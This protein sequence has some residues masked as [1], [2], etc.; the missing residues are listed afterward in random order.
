MAVGLLRGFRGLDYSAL[1][2]AGSELD[3]GSVVTAGAFDGLHRG[4]QH[5]LAKVVD[6]AKS[7]GLP[8]VAITFEPLPREFFAGS[9]RLPRLMSFREKYD[10]L[11]ELGI[12]YVL[13]VRFDD[14]IRTMSAEAF[15]KQLFVQELNAKH[16]II[17]D[18]FRF[19]ANAS[20]NFALLQSI[21]EKVGASVAAIDSQVVADERVS[22]SLIRQSLEQGN[23]E[24]AKAYLG[25]A[26]AI[27]GRVFPGQKLGRELGF[28]TANIQLRR[29]S[30]AMAGVYVVEVAIESG[31]LVDK[32]ATWLPAVANVGTK[33]TVT[34]SKTA[35]LEVHL[36]D[37][38]GD[39][40]GK[41]LTVR[42]LKKL[43]DE[44]KF[45]GLDALK[46]QIAIDTQAARD[47]FS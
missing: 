28:P 9:Q 29:R 22:S 3:A 45:S 14:T 30:T 20:G 38:Q 6:E 10:G 40:Y 21:L 15:A 16:V 13:L 5:L 46:Q 33:P 7:R 2:A 12:D 4:H 42:F 23:L 44:K 37:Y 8:S 26:Y 31:V 25:R 36:L 17:G 1:F 27:K 47:Y 43:R 11:H 34:R 18:D 41:R 32:E 24:A 19:G 39:L 35:T